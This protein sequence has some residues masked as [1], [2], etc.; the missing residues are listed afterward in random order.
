MNVSVLICT[1]NP[2]ADYFGR[3]L[4]SVHAQSLSRDGWEL[5]VIDNRSD[6]L[7]AP[8]IDLSWHPAARVVREDMLGLTPARLR[9]IRE[10]AGQLLIFVD[11][12]NVLDADY[13][14]AALRVAEEKPFLGSWSG[15]CRPQFEVPPPE[16][17]RRYW[18]NLVIREFDKDVW[19]NLP[20]LP[21]T[22]PCGAGLC[23]R[24]SVADHYLRLH[25]QR[26]RAFQL[27]RMGDSLLSGGDNDLAACACDIGLGVGLISA[28]KL[29]HLI[30]PQRLT[31][32]YLARLS[33][34]IQFSS[35]LLDA[36]WGKAAPARSASGRL[37]DFLR[38]LRLK[39]PHRQI[40]RAAYRGRDR[41]AKMLASEPSNWKN[42]L[43]PS[44]IRHTR[45]VLGL[46]RFIYGKRGEPYVIAGRTLRYTPGTRPVRTS[47][48]N[49]TNDNSR[50]DALQ[51]KLLAGHLREGHTA[52]DVGAHW[53]QYCI[54]MAAM[55]GATGNVVAFEPDRYARKVLMRNLQLNPSI[56]PPTVEAL[57]V[58]DAQGEAV[59]YS[60]GGNSLSSLARSGIGEAAAG[61]VENNCRASRDS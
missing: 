53:G 51:I 41:A 21:D 58:S 56:K 60:R 32:D 3:C 33:E 23:V 22:M 36:K 31:D 17:T 18:G 4:E 34:G 19:S 52:I 13:L 45:L 40:L 24:R 42:G 47:Y 8:R 37:L 10:A 44:G 1:Y 59:L 61:D 7:L 6:E 20:R 2:R 29:T 12:D 49:S 28:L 15:Q 57:A 46:K 14:E 9:G 27:D 55:C 54:L 35:T 39:P 30:P 38:T 50:Y 16:W 5:V 43:T 25:E 11:D 48:A 26:E